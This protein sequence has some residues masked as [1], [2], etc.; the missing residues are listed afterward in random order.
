[1]NHRLINIALVVG[2]LAT[3]VGI[4]FLDVSDV[5]TERAMSKERREW[6]HAVQHCLRAYGPQTQPEYTDDGKLI[7]VGARGQLYSEVK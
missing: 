3:M 2:I 1:M 4:Q 5:E 7:C 6:M